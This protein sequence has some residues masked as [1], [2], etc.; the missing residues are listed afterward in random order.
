MNMLLNEKINFKSLEENTF[1]IQKKQAETFIKKNAY[2]DT[3]YIKRR[4][5]KSFGRTEKRGSRACNGWIETDK[6]GKD[7]RL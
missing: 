5:P 1:K 7:K 6:R 3:V 2:V 4:L